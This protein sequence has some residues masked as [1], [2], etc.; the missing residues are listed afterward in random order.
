MSSVGGGA[1]AQA[2]QTPRAQGSIPTLD[3]SIAKKIA[4]L[5]ST[6]KKTKGPSKS[7]RKKCVVCVDI[8][9]STCGKFG[10]T[11]MTV[12]QKQVQVLDG[13]ICRYWKSHDI[14]IITFGSTARLFDIPVQEFND[15]PIYDLPSFTSGGGTETHLALELVQNADLCVVITDGQSGSRQ[16]ALKRAITPL[17]TY[18]TVLEILAVNCSEI[19]FQRL[20]EGF[21][22][23]MDLPQHIG[24]DV[25]KVEIYTPAPQYIENPFLAAQSNALK[26]DTIPFGNHQ[27]PKGMPIPQI[28]KFL[29]EVLESPFVCTP[30]EYLKFVMRCWGLIGR[31]DRSLLTN[32][33]LA[34]STRFLQKLY[35][36][37]PPGVSTEN[38]LR[39]AIHGVRSVVNQ[40]VDNTNLDKKV[41]A[42][43]TVE[44]QLS[45]KETDEFL[46]AKGTSAEKP[47]LDFLSTCGIFVS[48]EAG[49]LQLTQPVKA[50][51][52]SKT[53]NGLFV[54]GH[55]LFDQP[56]RQS[57]RAILQEMGIAD[58]DKGPLVSGAIALMMLQHLSLGQSIESEFMQTLTTLMKQQQGMDVILE[59]GRTPAEDKRS[60]PICQEWKA[61]RNPAV[62]PA[63]PDVTH[64]RLYA[65]GLNPWK[66]TEEMYWAVLMSLH[67]DDELFAAQLHIYASTLELLGVGKSW[68]EVLAYFVAQY[69]DYVSGTSEMLTVGKPEECIISCVT[70]ADGDPFFKILDHEN[71]DGEPCTYG[72]CLCVEEQ[73]TLVG[74]PWCGKAAWKLLMEHGY[75]KLPLTLLQEKIRDAKPFSIKVPHHL[76]CMVPECPLPNGPFNW[77]SCRPAAA[78]GGGAAAIAVVDRPAAIAVV[79]GRAAGGGAAFASAGGGAASVDVSA[80]NPAQSAPAS[81]IPMNAIFM[82]GSVGAGKS[83]ARIALV[84][85]LEAMGFVV[86][87]VNNDRLSK[88][89]QQKQANAIF[90]REVAEGKR[91][92]Q[93]KNVPYVVIFDICN[94]E[95]RIDNP[96]SFGIKLRGIYKCFTFMVNFD[97]KDTVGYRA[98]SLLN[99]LGRAP[100]SAADHWWLNPRDAGL[101]TC[102]KVSNTKISAMFASNGI[103]GIAA[104][105]TMMS[106]DALRAMLQPH[107]ERYAKTVRP[108]EENVRKF[109]ED[110]KLGK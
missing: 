67:Q 22:I 36:H 76:P 9:G 69:K 16:D 73:A 87:V 12:L 15:N 85:Q 107:V 86:V 59:K 71:E 19:D 60:G 54:I 39:F 43:N 13:L 5:P 108:V 57:L 32:K 83:T 17:K 79:G 106:E 70:F 68:Q 42:S 33:V 34:W 55:G 66:M 30:E 27:I 35:Q 14:Q 110:N 96:D 51:P 24:N 98:W 52:N 91:S 11:G 10:S 20:G 62:N 104:V 80:P 48:A 89:G 103:P 75:Y 97:A 77:S 47:I 99:V 102:I 31:F 37:A 105:D 78:G 4:T 74:C 100:P 38:I 28:A 29:V 94:E 81:T 92:A 40:Y 88:A 56:V 53:A 44:K 1:A 46:R 90:Q 49:V 21:P 25:S 63:T 93:S 50:F 23:G 95:F 45:F 26:G 6:K 82:V 61:G 58:A 3:E 64:A 72:S 84:S 2:S 7:G 41:A 8:S 65:Q 18:G 109:I 101:A